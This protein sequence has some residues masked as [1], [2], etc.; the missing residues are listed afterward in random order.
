MDQDVL[1]QAS[2]SVRLGQEKHQRLEQQ[3]L[4]DAT[5]VVAVS[6]LVQEDFQTMTDTPVE[7][8][9]N[10]FDE[11]DFDQVVEPDGYF[12]VTHTGLFASD[13]N[14]EVVWQAL[15]ENASLILISTR[16]C[17]SGLLERPTAKS[18]LP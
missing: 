16:C 18:Y 11:D 12:N 7:L 15:A 10:G 2:V 6:P 9:T 17:V 1:L 5:V 8:I 14:P 4:D 3:V 13:G